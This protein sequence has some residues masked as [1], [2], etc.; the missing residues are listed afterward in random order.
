MR[1]A[2][3]EWSNSWPRDLSDARCS[4]EGKQAL[5]SHDLSRVVWSTNAFADISYVFSSANCPLMYRIKSLAR[6][7]Y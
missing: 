3:C 1:S 6:I 2:I 4:K 5:I 7:S